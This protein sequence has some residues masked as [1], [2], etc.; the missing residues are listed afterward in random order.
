MS[1]ESTQTA[2][3]TDERLHVLWVP[4]ES[5]R[6]N[7]ENPRLNDPAVEPVMKSIARFG[8]RVPIVVNRRTNLIE[9]GNTR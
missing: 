5:V 4:L 6:L 1:S 8:C 3:R 7:P 2:P 9:A